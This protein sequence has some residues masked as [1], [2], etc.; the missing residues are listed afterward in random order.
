MQSTKV[1]VLKYMKQIYAIQKRDLHV[2]LI[3][4]NTD[5]L[6]ETEKGEESVNKITCKNCTNNWYQE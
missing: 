2:V 1:I 6:H 5:A 4:F 3:S